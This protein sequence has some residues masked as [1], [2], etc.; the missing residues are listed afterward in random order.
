VPVLRHLLEASPT[1]GVAF[2]STLL[3]VSALLRQ[4]TFALGGFTLPSLLNQ[5]R[6][7]CHEDCEDIRQHSLHRLFVALHPLALQAV[8]P[9][10]RLDLEGE[11]AG[12]DQLLLPTLVVGRTPPLLIRCQRPS[13]LLLL[14]ADLEFDLLTGDFREQF[15]P[16]SLPDFAALTLDRLE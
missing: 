11:A 2:A 5:Q 9:L 14:F 7:R 15:A 3:F 10:P 4:L 13:L 12:R 6:S 8:W 1:I 16:L